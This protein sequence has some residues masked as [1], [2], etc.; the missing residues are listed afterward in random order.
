VLLKCV[1]ALFICPKTVFWTS[2]FEISAVETI[3]GCCTDDDF[4]DG[5]A[6]RRHAVGY[7]LFR[8][9]L[10]LAAGRRPGRLLYVRQYTPFRFYRL[11]L[12]LIQD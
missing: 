5:M 11:I 7:K 10:Y 6:G 2:T 3:N 1:R 9:D 12:I 4:Y 8:R